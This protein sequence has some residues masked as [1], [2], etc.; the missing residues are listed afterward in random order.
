MA[1]AII[2]FIY[3]GQIIKFACKKNELMKNIFKKYLLKI[4]KSIKNVCFLYKGY[5]INGDIKLEQINNKDKEIQIYVVPVNNIKKEVIKHS[6]DI[7]CPE[8]G[9]NCL[10]SIDNYKIGLNNCKNG[11]NLTNIL[12]EEYF[13]IQKINELTILC[14][15][16]KKNSKAKV[17][18]NQFYKCCNCNIN[19]CPPCKSKHNKEHIII[20]YELKNYIC[21]TH[22]ENYM[23]YCKTCN[24]NLCR[25]CELKHD[26]KHK[27]TNYKEILKN[28]SVNK[29]LNELRTKIDKL[30]NEIKYI[31][32]IFNKVIVNLE[33]YYNI[34]KTIINNSNIKNKN[35]QSL[36]NTNN[37][38]DFNLNIIKDIN[39]IVNEN[40]I[41]SKVK[42][43]DEIYNK[44]LPSNEIIA[45]YRVGNEPTIRILG[46]NFLK[47]NKDNYEMI[48]NGKKSELK[49]FFN[50][51]D[52]KIRKNILEVKLR[53]IKPVT[54][55]SYMFCNCTSLLSLSDISKWNTT[56]VTSMKGMFQFCSS[57]LFLPSIAKINTENVKDMSYMFCGC[58]SLSL[59][60][61]ISKWNTN[62][63]T[64]MGDMFK[65][66]LNIIFSKIIKEK[67]KIN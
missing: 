39:R 7:I 58:S 4:N 17:N 33:L 47:N 35:Y 43:I 28:K 55:L 42:Y 13:D 59:L 57:L 34:S 16:C 19:L 61:D 6:K 23:S 3:N 45:K 22:G 67:F 44:S 53:E 27:L 54:D 21:K 32:N 1:D 31:I 38:N 11:H 66:C 65:G 2:D 15:D 26:K 30:K 29:N 36:V 25:K 10:L 50:I 20:D 46:D 18:N 51:N 52:M 9:E 62:E 63:I 8:C 41:E 37:I 56:N 64:Y 12:F 5:K 60:P 14:N 24:I 40:K 48:I 49:T